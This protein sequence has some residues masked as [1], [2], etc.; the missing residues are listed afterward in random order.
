MR[1]WNCTCYVLIVHTFTIHALFVLPKVA[2]H[3]CKALANAGAKIIVGTWPPVLGIFQKSLSA[4]KF[5]EDMMLEDGS[6]TLN[7]ISFLLGFAALS[8]FSRAFKRWTGLPPSASRE[9]NRA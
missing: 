8:A 5:D 9:S 6:K 4:G 1:V 7:E 3:S 2:S